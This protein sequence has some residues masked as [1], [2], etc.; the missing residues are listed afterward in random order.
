MDKQKTSPSE[1]PQKSRR[2]FKI[3]VIAGVGLLALLLI[4]GGLAI[5]VSSSVSPGDWPLAEK[6]KGMVSGGKRSTGTPSITLH[7]MEPFLVNLADPGQFRYLK[8]TLHV[9]AKQKGDEFE[10]RLPQSRDT[11]L[12]VLSSKISR[13][14]MTSEGKNALRE[15]IRE[16]MNQVLLETKVKNIY[17]TEFVIQ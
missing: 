5:L 16:K 3:L 8:V 17:F 1:N 6:I 12:N 10:R 15:E 14:L 2:S 7:K 4:G 11:V 13:D 9:E